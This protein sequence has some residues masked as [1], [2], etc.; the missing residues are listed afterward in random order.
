MDR[1]DRT[2]CLSNLRQLGQALA[3]YTAD[4]GHYPAAEMEVTDASGRVIERKR[5]Y[6]ALGPYLDRG[7]RAWSSGQGRVQVDPVTG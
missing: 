4:H 2:V 5:W 6:R 3:E 7:P 1:A